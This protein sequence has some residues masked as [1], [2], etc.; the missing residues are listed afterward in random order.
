MLCQRGPKV[1]LP[2][3]KNLMKNGI[4]LRYRLVALILAG[5]LISSLRVWAFEEPFVNLGASSFF[6]GMAAIANSNAQS[7]FYFNEYLQWYTAN[8]FNNNHGDAIPG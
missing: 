4:V 8:R 6:D 5:L 2:S 1:Q 7:G 3:M